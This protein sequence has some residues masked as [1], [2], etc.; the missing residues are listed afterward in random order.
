MDQRVLC[1]G[2]KNPKFWEAYLYNYFSHYRRALKYNTASSIIHLEE[3]PWVNPLTIAILWYHCWYLLLWGL[4]SSELF[5]SQGIETQHKQAKAVKGIYF[6]WKIIY[7]EWSLRGVGPGACRKLLEHFL[8]LTWICF[9][10]TDQESDCQYSESCI[11]MTSSWKAR[12]SVFLCPCIKY[13]GRFWLVLLGHPWPSNWPA[14]RILWP[15]TV[16]GL[17]IGKSTGITGAGT[18]LVSHP[19]LADRHV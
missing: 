7:L 8:S 11:L 15:A 14:G 13:Q 5:Q 18:G 2:I 3:V 19:C 6:K 16:A 17:L 4:Y 12:T 10:K 1:I 9:Q